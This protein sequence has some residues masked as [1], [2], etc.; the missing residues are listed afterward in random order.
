VPGDEDEGQSSG[1]ATDRQNIPVIDPT[2]N[3]LDLVNAETK[4]QDDLRELEYSHL[5]QMAKLEAKHAKEMRLAESRRV[6]AIR[7]AE[8]RRIDAIR[9]VDVAATAS[10]ASD[11]TTRANT[12][13]GQVTA[14][15]DVTRVALAAAL[16]PIQKDIAELR[17]AQYEAPGV[18][19]QAQTG[20]ERE[21]RDTQR[22]SDADRRARMALVISGVVA[23]FAFLSLAFTVMAL[24]S[25]QP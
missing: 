20:G 18:I 25:R 6:D 13:A 1:P 10:A 4:R 21:S 15:A 3:V 22:D 17:R 8:T 11:T 5:R 9:A 7:K 2:K 19:A 14:A 12:L 23:L 16:D 24:V